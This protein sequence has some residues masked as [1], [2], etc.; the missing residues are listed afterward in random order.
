MFFKRKKGP[1]KRPA[2][3][4]PE[5]TLIGKKMTE[6]LRS[7]LPV[8][9]TVFFLC[10]F[11]LPVET[12][13][14]LF[15]LMGAF[16]LTV[17]IAIFQIGAE[18]SM[19]QIGLQIGSYLS[20]SRKLWPLLLCSFLLGVFITVSEP[21]LQ[22]LAGSFPNIPNATMIFAVAFGVGLFL[23]VAI[24]RVLLRVPLRVILLASY[25]VTV[26][27]AF[28][29]DP[30]Y[31]PVSFDAGGVT[32][33]PMT[34]P[35]IISLGI[36]ISALRNDK[37]AESDS[38]GYIA[39]CSIG[40]ILTMLIL[41]F[42]FP[43]SSS[44]TATIVPSAGSTI[45][46]F[47]SFTERFPYYIKEVLLALL[48]VLCFF[49]VF[50]IFFIKLPKHAFRKIM[51]G[52]LYTFIGLVLFLTGANVGFMPM[53]RQIGSMIGQEPYRWAV[54][55]VAAVLGYFTVRAEPAVQVLTRQV[56]EMTAGS[57]PEK[58]MTTSLS[59]GVAI[60]TSLAFSRTVFSF[61]ILWLVIPGYVIALALSFFVDP[62]FTSV[63]FDSGGI[64]S[65]PL[66]SAFI[67]P[68]SI[69]LCSSLGKDEGLYAFGI[70]ALVALFPIITIQILGL[71]YKLLR[72]KA[73]RSERNEAGNDEIIELDYAG[74]NGP[75]DRPEKQGKTK[76]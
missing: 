52:L 58:A 53:G 56:Y 18:N 19:T 51:V 73:S 33:G 76:S 2:R 62:I 20:K 36:G 3:Y 38:F 42:I 57:I 61:S 65:G 59:V 1:E 32:T 48:P 29:A 72:A 35:F 60:A 10:F 37:D 44:P 28:F 55:P 68:I 5:K 39:L 23:I 25:G 41:S 12:D 74:G 64:A 75:E 66:T 14:L 26:L 67:L 31:L 21:D 24:L 11:I 63:A 17:G 43:S 49:L 9:L 50:Q 6:S 13:V 45:D 69:G 4:F 7:V 15:F 70:V 8:T 34:V 27:L 46:L 54:I 71:I 16:F 47:S 22:I 30:G 40:P